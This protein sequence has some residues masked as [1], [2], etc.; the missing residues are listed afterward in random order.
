[1]FVFAPLFFSYSFE[2]GVLIQTLV[3]FVLFSLTASAIY[4]LNDIKDVDS[5]RQHPSKKNR[6]LASGEV[7]IKS[8]WIIFLVLASSAMVISSIY[9]WELFQVLIAYFILNVAYSMGLKHVALVDVCMI[10]VGFILRLF[11]GSVFLPQQL[12][13]WIIVMT[14]LLAT[15]L[16]I[17]KRRDDVVL[18]LSGKE[19]RKNVDG[20]NL[21]FVNAAMTFMSAVIIVCYIQYTIS[22]EVILRLQSN[23]IYLTS[24]FVILGIL[25]Y[26]QITFVENKSG[27]PTMIVLTDRFLQLTILAWLVSFLVFYMV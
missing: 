11:A 22:D 2:S 21:E 7:S 4:V 19:T 6:P 3:A 23:Y 9:H 1:M 20:Y 14:F 12:S 27:S 5:D 16:A 18:S 8:A 13:M 15:F 10:S 17:A 24:V 25:R 26:M